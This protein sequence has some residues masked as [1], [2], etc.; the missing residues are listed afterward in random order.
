MDKKIE[1]KSV[2]E[3]KT[4]IVEM[5]PDQFGVWTKIQSQ[6]EKLSTFVSK[7]KAHLPAVATGIVIGAVATAALVFL[8]N[9]DDENDDDDED[10]DNESEAIVYYET[11]A[12]QNPT[13][14]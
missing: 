3:P 1:V 12:E 13:E 6:N 7:A 9:S 14:S 4:V 2:E 10:Q 5:T 8:T 11:R